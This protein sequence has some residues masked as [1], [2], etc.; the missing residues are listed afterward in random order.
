MNGFLE[1]REQMPSLSVF[2]L[3]YMWT[4]SFRG[5]SSDSR[6]NDRV[7][8]KSKSLLNPVP[9]ELVLMDLKF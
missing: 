5:T 8:E 3:P 7:I 1:R 6:L 4:T 9:C 2:I